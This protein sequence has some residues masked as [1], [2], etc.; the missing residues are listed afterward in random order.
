MWQALLTLKNNVLLSAI[1]N[2]VKERTQFSY[3]DKK[4]CLKR[5]VKS[6]LS[7]TLTKCLNNKYLQVFKRQLLL[8]HKHQL[9]GVST[10]EKNDN[11]KK[12]QASRKNLSGLNRVNDLIKSNQQT[13][14]VQN[15]QRESI[16]RQSASN[17]LQNSCELGKSQSLYG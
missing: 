16:T 15:K 3:K 8:T 13:R 14:L 5:S 1:I 11:N 4:T 9:K 12:Y 10:Y 7:K 6:S 17:K 2:S